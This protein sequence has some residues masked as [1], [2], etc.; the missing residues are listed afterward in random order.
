[1]AIEAFIS[2]RWA[3]G[4]HQF[5]MELA[6]KLSD[7]VDISPIVDESTLIAG[8]HI[9]NWM[10]NAVEN[11]DVFLFVISPG[12]L[13]STNCRF[14]LRKA[15]TYGKPI[16][17]VLLRKAKLPKFLADLKWIDFSGHMDLPFAKVNELVNAI[18]YHAGRPQP[19]STREIPNRALTVR[20][21]SSR[22][23]ADAWIEKLPASIKEGEHLVTKFGLRIVNASTI[24]GKL[25]ISLKIT[26]R[27]VRFGP[28][29]DFRMF[30]TLERAVTITPSIDY[31]F[32]HPLTIAGGQD[33]AANILINF[34][35]EREL[36][37]AAY[38]SRLALPIGSRFP[39]YIVSV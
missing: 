29:A 14:E 31:V 3:D 7:Y 2:H 17:P 25:L 10:K 34:V 12:S 13:E 22:F 24:P 11:A 5:T 20:G 27:L 30:D 15:R 36:A 32:E 8:E 21:I 4:E 16:I 28:T 19:E 6:R 9:R 18:R 37:A 1:V 26:G 35:P 39:D 33:E 23:L 38:V